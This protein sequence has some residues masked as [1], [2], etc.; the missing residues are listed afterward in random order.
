MAEDPAIA[1]A[2]A[3]V[4]AHQPPTPTDEFPVPMQ[5]SGHMETE[6]LT[7]DSTF[8]NQDDYFGL[9]HHENF[10]FPDGVSYVTIKKLNE[11]DRKSYVNQ[12]NRRL[13]I[14]RATGDAEM[15][16]APG[17][18]KHNLLEKAIVGW[19]LAR[20]G[21]NGQMQPV[22]FNNGTLKQFLIKANPKL[23]DDIEAFIHRLNPW[24]DSD[25]TI[26]ELEKE[27]AQLTEVL[28]RKRAEEE[29]KGTSEK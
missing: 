12:S 11:G 19:N 24:L 9:D 13:A 6:V 1:A 21:D 25:A 26:E 17:D 22:P 5:R 3:H 7:A 18:E 4:Q 29:G 27:I 2:R 14:K 16:M 23:I 10:L 8:P 15:S 20:R 28:E